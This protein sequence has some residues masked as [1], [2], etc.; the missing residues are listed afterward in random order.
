M[1]ARVLLK[2]K[3]LLNARTRLLDDPPYPTGATCTHSCSKAGSAFSTKAF[4]PSFWSRVA[5]VE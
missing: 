4:M 5:K 1:Y 3:F 2:V